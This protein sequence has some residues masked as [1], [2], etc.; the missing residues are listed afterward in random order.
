MLP[1]FTG[2]L[3]S[4]AF[5]ERHLPAT[6]PADA[7]RLRRELVAWRARSAVLGPASTPRTIL[8]AAAAPLCAALGFEA[9]A[10]IEPAHPAVAATLRASG[11]AVA[12]LVAPWGEPLDPLWRLAVAQATRRAAPWCLLFDGLRLR[13]VDAGRLYARRHVEF[14]LDLAIDHPPA[15]A[16]LWTLAGSAALTSGP[17]HARS[18]H[19]LVA[20]SDRHAAGVCRSLRDGVLAASG[21]CSRRSSAAHPR[22]ATA[23]TTHDLH[24]RAAEIST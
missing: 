7:D 5:V 23:D 18:L 4:V 15:V 21:K 20:A 11:R 13:I 9:P 19:A 3:L 1:G 22:S 17:G 16:A 2:H 14:D 8:H 10:A 12:L 6:A 24:P